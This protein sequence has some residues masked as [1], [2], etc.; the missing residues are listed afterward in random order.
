MTQPI[1]S[2]PTV[3]SPPPTTAPALSRHTGRE[4]RRSGRVLPASTR[5]A[6]ISHGLRAALASYG[7]A[8]WRWIIA[9]ARVA[10]GRDWTHTRSM[11]SKDDIFTARSPTPALKAGVRRTSR[12]GLHT[13]RFAQSQPRVVRAAVL[14]DI[15]PSINLSGLLGIKRYVGKLPRSVRWPTPLD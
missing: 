4:R 9:D 2:L 8:C 11:S 10:M 1:A 14:N 13:M 15:G 5:A 6:T 3:S 12:G 7:R